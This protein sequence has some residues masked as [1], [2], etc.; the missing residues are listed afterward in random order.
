MSWPIVC[1]FNAENYY[2]GLFG[3]GGGYGAYINDIEKLGGVYHIT[4]TEIVYPDGPAGVLYNRRYALAAMQ[5]M[6]DQE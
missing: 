4:Y 5:D 6:P 2:S 3:V 1:I